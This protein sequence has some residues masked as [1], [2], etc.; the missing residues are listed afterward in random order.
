MQ[1]PVWEE[2]RA[3]TTVVT[4]YTFHILPPLVADL[5]VSSHYE[6]A[7]VVSV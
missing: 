2:N 1:R 6:E 7:S 4:V 5:L 3:A